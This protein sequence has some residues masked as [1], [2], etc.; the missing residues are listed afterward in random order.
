MTKIGRETISL[1]GLVSPIDQTL[2]EVRNLGMYMEQA[3]NFGHFS[4][5]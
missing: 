3:N 5:K 2:P 4:N 1:I